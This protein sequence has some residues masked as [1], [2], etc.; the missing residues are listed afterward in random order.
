[1][2][3]RHPAYFQWHNNSIAPI[4]HW[5]SATLM[6]V[7]TVGLVF[8][9]YI[10]KT[11]AAQLSWQGPEG[12]SSWQRTYTEIGNGL[13]LGQSPECCSYVTDGYASIQARPA[14]GMTIDWQSSSLISMVNTEQSVVLSFKPQSCSGYLDHTTNADAQFSTDISTLPDSEFLC[15]RAHLTTNNPNYSPAL[16]SVTIDYVT[17]GTAPSPTPC[18]P[19]TPSD[20]GSAPA[21]VCPGGTTVSVNADTHVRADL[22]STNFGGSAIYLAN[23]DANGAPTSYTMYG[24]FRFPTQSISPNATTIYLTLP[25]YDTTQTTSNGESITLQINRLITD[26]FNESTVTWNDLGSASLHEDTT[27]AYAKSTTFSRGSLSRTT[28]LLAQLDVTQYVKDVQSGAIA[29]TG[30]LV[31]GT[32]LDSMGSGNGSDFLLRIDPREDGLRPAY[33]SWTGGCDTLP[34]GDPA[35]DPTPTQTSTFFETSTPT[36][37]STFFYS[38]SPTPTTTYF[39]LPPYS[40]PPSPTPTSTFFYYPTPTPTWSDAFFYP[41]P[42]PT[43]TYPT[44][45]PTANTGTPNPTTTFFVD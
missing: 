17:V 31:S 28:P 42:T 43:T 7:I 39:T 34:N 36:P 33:V 2:S 20:C 29:N 4:F 13:V 9:S 40:P 41:T 44:T 6:L 21:N 45:F 37:T 11:Q 38:P 1:M 8:S 14:P 32:S 16:N 12:F 22:P 18:P 5:A 24:L 23:E 30:F 35:P 26:P 10:P 25:V 27:Y 19:N 15:I 3:R